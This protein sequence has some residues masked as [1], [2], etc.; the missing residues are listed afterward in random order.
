ML[1]HLN[2]FNSMDTDSAK[3]HKAAVFNPCLLGE[4][5]YQVDERCLFWATIEC[6]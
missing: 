2:I 3:Y 5:P 1:N 4:L 6:P